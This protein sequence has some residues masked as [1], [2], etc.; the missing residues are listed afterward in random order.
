MTLRRSNRRSQAIAYKDNH[1]EDDS[2]SSTPHKK[3]NAPTSPDSSCG[4]SPVPNKKSKATKRTKTTKKKTT[5]KKKRI[6]DEDSDT[7]DES[8]VETSPAVK[9][10]PTSMKKPQSTF[11][12]DWR[13]SSVKDY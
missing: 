9:K 1:V 2:V 13:V 6:I 3:R 5:K 4:S 11:G 10:T 8:I 7:A 12:S